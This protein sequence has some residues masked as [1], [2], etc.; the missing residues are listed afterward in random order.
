M[1]VAGNVSS[2][3]SEH[4]VIQKVAKGS[5][6]DFRHLVSA[7]QEQIYLM[8]LK[9]VGDEQIARELTQDTF[10]KAYLN[11]S[12]FRFQ[13]SFSTW[14]TR[15]ALNSTSS[16]FT[17]KR[18]KQ[19]QRTIT[20]DATQHRHNNLEADDRFDDEAIERLR[21][22]IARL[23][24]IY[25]DVLTLCALERKSYE[26]AATL[27]EVPIGTVRSRLNKAR[28]LLRKMYFKV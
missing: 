10:L 1:E 16:Y 6:N 7:H 22:A 5:R 26:E 9:S 25:R 24:P 2:E 20:F 14:L 27:L 13:S 3:F 19:K 17:S 21:L 23:K 8:I 12:K 11:I 18:F 28:N 4:E 15:I